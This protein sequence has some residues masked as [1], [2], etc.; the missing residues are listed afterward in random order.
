MHTIDS[1]IIIYVINSENHPTSGTL[2]VNIDGKDIKD[3]KDILSEKEIPFEQKAG[4]LS[5]PLQVRKN[6]VMVLLIHSSL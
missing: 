5:I 1:T 4:E 2:E 6:Q 3:V